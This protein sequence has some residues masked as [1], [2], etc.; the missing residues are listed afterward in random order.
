MKIIPK[1]KLIIRDSFKLA[2]RG[3]EI[4]CE[5]L[6]AL[7]I[8]TDIV[9]EKFLKDMETIRR[10]SSSAFIS[11]NLTATLVQKD[12]AELII[13]KLLNVDRHLIKVVFIGLD[14]TGKKLFTS[15]LKQGHCAFSYQFI[16]DLEKAKEWLID[17][18][19]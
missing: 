13:D 3:G 14:H 7:S 19:F 1:E 8:H 2:Y 11:V 5:E 6:D 16:D 18:K 10:P 4:W 15:L 9:A 12:I 17:V